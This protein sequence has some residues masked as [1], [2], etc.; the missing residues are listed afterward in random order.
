MMLSIVIPVYNEAQSQALL[1]PELRR[2]AG[3][4]RSAMLTHA[5][6]MD[7]RLNILSFSRK[8]DGPAGTRLAKEQAVA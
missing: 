8:F 7:S 4:A 6:A 3:R 2:G 5:A 1:L